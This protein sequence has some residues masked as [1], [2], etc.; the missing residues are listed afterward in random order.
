[1]L[2]ELLGAELFAQVSEK[3]G[4]KK[5]GIVNDGSWLPKAK[6]DE[7]I[8]TI[9]QLKAD[10]QA[11]DEQLNGLQESVKGNEE[12]TAKIN[13]LQQANETAKSEFEQKLLDTQLSAALKMH[14]NG[15]VHDT[16]LVLGLLDKSKIKLDENGNIAEGLDE[17]D[18]TL[19]ESKGFLFVSDTEPDVED[20]PPITMSAGNTNPQGSQASDPFA[21]IMAEYEN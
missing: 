21:A 5:L 9:N 16:D 20:K 14:Y 13:E 8:E 6:L 10:L 1:M 4:D 19:K 15:K 11:R 2:E 3:L 18:A 17:Q 7:K 12:L